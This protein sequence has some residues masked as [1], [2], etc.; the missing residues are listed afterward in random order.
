LPSSSDPTGVSP[1]PN[2]IVD[3]LCR[4]ELGLAL[5]RAAVAE[6]TAEVYRARVE[7]LEQQKSPATQRPNPSQ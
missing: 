7:Q 1:D 6:E 2:K 3:R 5:W 4:T